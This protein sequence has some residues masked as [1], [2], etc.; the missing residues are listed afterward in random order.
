M[1]ADTVYAL[2]EKTRT[3]TTAKVVLPE[4]WPNLFTRIEREAAINVIKTEQKSIPEFPIF[5]QESLH[6]LKDKCRRK[7]CIMAE[8]KMSS[9]ITQIT[10]H[11]SAT[12]T[13]F[14]M[15]TSKSWKCPKNNH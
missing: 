4:E 15:A 14:K 5:G 6:L 10:E 1:E 12:S 3:D 2:K 13:L 11:R 9:V 7:T 8:N